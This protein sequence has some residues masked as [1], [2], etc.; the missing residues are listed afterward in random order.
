MILTAPHVTKRE[1]AETAMRRSWFPVARIADLDSPQRATLLGEKLVVWRDRNGKVSVQSRRCPHR[2]GDLSRG[3]VHASSIGC[4]YHGWEFGSE[5]GACTRIPSLPD[6]AKIPP[7]A[8]IASYPVELRYGHVWTVLEDPIRDIYEVEEWDG[9]DLEWLAADPIDSGVG[10]GVSATSA[11]SRT[12]RSCTRCRW[13]PR[14]KSSSRC[15]SRV[16]A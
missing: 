16:T 4:P 11:M 15:R 9:V 13:A 6:Q 5:G 3:E 1:L 2:G 14:R 8:A 7:K 12:S 10:V